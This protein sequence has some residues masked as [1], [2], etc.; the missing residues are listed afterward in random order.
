MLLNLGCDVTANNNTFYAISIPQDV[1]QIPKN[2][3]HEALKKGILH[4]YQQQSFNYEAN[5]PSDVWLRHP[6]YG[7]HVSLHW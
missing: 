5:M 6:F 4:T 3:V 1:S 2:L 7:L